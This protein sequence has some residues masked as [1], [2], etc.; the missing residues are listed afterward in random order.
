MRS[1]P[2]NRLLITG[3]ITL[4]VVLVLAYLGGWVSGPQTIAFTQPTAHAPEYAPSTTGNGYQPES[5]INRD[6]FV[7]TRID[8]HCATATETV[9]FKIGH[10]GEGEDDTK[11]GYKTTSIYSAFGCGSHPNLAILTHPGL[12]IVTDNIIQAAYITI[13]RIAPRE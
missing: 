10:L 6:T 1:N 2:T 3:I 12:I 9:Q 13:D 5:P 7:I 8:I 4:T 11:D